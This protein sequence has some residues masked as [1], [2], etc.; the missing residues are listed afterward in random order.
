MRHGAFA[1]PRQR[2]E[3]GEVEV[4][5]SLVVTRRMR[6]IERCPGAGVDRAG[7]FGPIGRLQRPDE[8][9]RAVRNV[10]L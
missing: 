3:L 4:R 10:E 1:L 8:R 9:R 7:F 2:I 5:V 6:L